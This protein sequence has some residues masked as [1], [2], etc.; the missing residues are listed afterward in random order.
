MKKFKF[1]LVKKPEESINYSINL[2]KEKTSSKNP[3]FRN[4]KKE[5]SVHKN[6]GKNNYGFHVEY[7]IRFFLF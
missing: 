1:F 4:K 3:E 5:N 7:R 6:G 2:R